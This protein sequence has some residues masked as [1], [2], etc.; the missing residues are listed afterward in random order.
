MNA[1]HAPTLHRMLACLPVLALA[2]AAPLFLSC[3]AAPVSQTATTVRKD[4]SNTEAARPERTEEEQTDAS[5]KTAA[6]AEIA[7]SIPTRD[8][9]LPADD[10]STDGVVVLRWQVPDNADAIHAFFEAN[11]PTM[12]SDSVQD[13]LLGNGIRVAAIPL[14]DLGAALDTLGGTASSI[15]L[16]LGQAHAWTQ[17]N[18]LPVRGQLAALIDGS[19]RRLTGGTLQLLIRGWTVPLEQGAVTDVEVQPTFLAGGAVPGA[20]ASARESFASAGFSLALERGTA[21]LVASAPPRRQSAEKGPAAGP[22][23]LPP[24]T[25]GELLL[26]RQGG[27]RDLLRLRPIV[28]IAPLVA[29]RHFSD[30]AAVES[31]TQPA[32][33]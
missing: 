29:D 16:W 27:D 13:R 2:A 32:Q 3:N 25:L 5:D 26:G 18:A 11:K 33:P 10:G 24:A 17:V 23:A 21:L 19:A 4:G 30:P 8:V 7:A 12:L 6:W 15:R 28:V 31:M 9:W 20:R 22:P 14:A 1:L